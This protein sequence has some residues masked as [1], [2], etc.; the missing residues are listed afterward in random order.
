[1]ER[2][3]NVASIVTTPLQRFRKLAV[4]LPKDVRS[5]VHER[6]HRPEL[7]LRIVAQAHCDFPNVLLYG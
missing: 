2:R 7:N 1:M 5:D 6:L 4:H 3:N